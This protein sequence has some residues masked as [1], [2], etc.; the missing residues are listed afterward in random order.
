MSTSESSEIFDFVVVGGGPAGIALAA[1]LARSAQAPKVLLLEAGGAKV[2]EKALLLAERFSTFI[3]YPDYN[4][5]YKT[6]PQIHLKDRI[7]DYSRGRGVG[8]SSRINFAAYTIGPKGDYD[9]WSELVGDDFF[10]WQ[11]TRRRFNKIEAYETFGLES[12]KYIDIQ[13]EHGRNGPIKVHI[14][15]S[16]ER[17]YTAVNDAILQ[18][19]IWDRNLDTNSGDPIGEALWYHVAG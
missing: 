7:I 18:C 5:G 12:K 17:G 19:G 3:N 13:T 10:N 9:H 1:S 11:N 2:D 4:W 14:P 8:G 15:P 6:V 16:F